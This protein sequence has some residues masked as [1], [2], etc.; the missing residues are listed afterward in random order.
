MNDDSVLPGE[1]MDRLRNEIEIL[2]RKQGVAPR[3][4]NPDAKESMSA[5]SRSINSLLRIFKEASEDM[6]MDTHDAV[7][8]AQKLDK[9]L[10]R[11]DKVEAQNEKIAKGIVAIAD[12]LEE[13]Q[14]DKPRQF[15]AP[16]RSQPMSP[17]QMQMQFSGGPE[18]KPL[19][20]YNL[21]PDD[22]KKSFLNLKM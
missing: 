18:P 12:M 15:S 6:K 20:T 14:E 4:D 3:E 13:Q 1:E 19:P 5:L 8:V 21:P 7:L 9:I 2:K 22:K 17:Q 16:S 11:L 10:D